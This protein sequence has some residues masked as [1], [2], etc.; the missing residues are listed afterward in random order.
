MLYE[1]TNIP[2]RKNIEEAYRIISECASKWQPKCFAE[3][4]NLLYHLGYLIDSPTKHRVT[5]ARNSLSILKAKCDLAEF[6]EA[7]KLIS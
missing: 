7:T 2:E 3:G 5:K 4:K 6:D 1:L